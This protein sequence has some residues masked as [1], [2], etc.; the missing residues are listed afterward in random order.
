M[1]EPGAD[2]E[3][4]VEVGRSLAEVTSLL[5]LMGKADEA[6][7]DRTAGWS[8]CWRARWVRTRRCGRS[9]R[10]AA[11][12]WPGSCST[13]A[14][15]TRRWRP[16]CGRG[17]TWKRWHGTRGLEQMSVAIWPKRSINCLPPVVLRASPPRPRASSARRWRSTRSWQTKTPLCPSSASTG[18]GATIFL[19]KSC[20][21]RA[22]RR[23]GRPNS[24]GHWRSYQ[25]LV[26]G[27]P[28]VTVFRRNLAV[29]RQCIGTLLLETGKPAEAEA[30]LRAALQIEQK[31][32]DEDPGDIYFRSGLA[33]CH[34]KLGR[35]LLQMGKPV[36]AG[37][38]CRTAVA[39]WQK[40][41]EDTPGVALYRCMLAQSVQ[42]LGDVVRSVGRF[43]EAKAA[44]ERA[45]AL[46]E[47][48]VREEP[49]ISLH[50]YDLACLV[51]RRGLAL[52]NLGDPAG[53]A[54]DV[55]RA[56]QSLDGLPFNSAGSL[57]QKACCHAA[58][59]GL[60]G[61]PES[62]ISAGEGEEAA[63]KAMDCLSRAVADGYR[64]V[65]EV[66][67]ETALDPLRDRQD[68][69]KLMAELEKKFPGQQ[70]KK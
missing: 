63:A 14:S 5:D 33:E 65:H 9:W 44:Y 70:E 59:A 22:S 10:P 2:I 64:N 21:T 38:E 56:L 49:T 18:R 17:P 69:K 48:R 3:A 20:R 45:I 36:E 26:S 54:E 37:A 31:L 57:F 67:I 32:V 50:R 30:E 4:K 62:R 68:F 66:R 16:A 13:R 11:R 41:V 34:T 25:E 43:A 42:N 58:L 39:I 47:P 19:A 40:L 53:A 52:V 7:G 6:R 60:A 8:R 24:A 29:C 46:E 15:L 55:R 35:L 23:R 51:R 1:A 27:N 61:Q 28:A 12:G